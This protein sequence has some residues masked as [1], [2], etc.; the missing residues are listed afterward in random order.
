MALLTLTT[1]FGEADHYAAAMKG[2]ILG[3]APRAQIVDITHQ[4]Q[5]FQIIE[6]AFVI[7]EACR[8]FP[9]KT[10]HIVVVDPGVGSSRRPILVEAAGQY[11]TGP[12]NGVLSLIY[13]R[14]ASKVR[15]LT[16]QRYWLPNPSN[17]FHGRDIFA[18]VTAHLAKGVR[19][20]AMGPVIEDY[21]RPRMAMPERIGSRSWSGSVL[22][23]DRFGNLITNLHVDQFPDLTQRPII[24]MAGV[25]AIKKRV[26]NFSQGGVNEP[27]VL[28]GSS[29]YL[30]VAVNQGS[31]A[32][33]LGCGAGAPVELT[34]Y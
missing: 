12:D 10:I 27:V 11:F 17:T 4:I 31:A 20:S 19:P 16:N 3:I 15:E 28:I 23:V 22:K 2:V 21:L 24:V 25:W 33:M 5:P 9:K 34:I 1:D 13:S 18:P 26:E 8:H 30:E 29:G 32:R 14:T 6:G 7:A